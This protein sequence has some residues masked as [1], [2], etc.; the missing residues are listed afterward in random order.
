VVCIELDYYC[1]GGGVPN[2]AAERQG[3]RRLYTLNG[4]CAGK[5]VG[6]R[7]VHFPHPANDRESSPQLWKETGTTVAKG[8]ALDQLACWYS[9]SS[10]V[11]SRRGHRDVVVSQGKMCTIEDTPLAPETS[12]TELFRNLGS[13]FSNWRAL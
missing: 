11:L 10:R 9:L 2:D 7:V 5:G 6:A 13:S 8:F 12:T 3:H 4:R 1:L